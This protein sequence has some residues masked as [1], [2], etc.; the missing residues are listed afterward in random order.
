V[1]CDP[2]QACRRFTTAALRHGGFGVTSASTADQAL[3]ILRRRLVKAMVIDPTGSDGVEALRAIRLRTEIPVIVVSRLTDECDKVAMLD[4]GA[5]DYL[6]KPFGSEELLARLRVALRRSVQPADD[7]PVETPDF[8]IDFGARRFFRRDGSE[9]RLTPTEWLL[10]E[11]LARRPGRVVGHA[12]LL[13]KVWG[14]TH[15]NA[16][17]YLR[18]YMATIR[19]KLEPDPSHPRYFITSPGLGLTFLPDRLPNRPQM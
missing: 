12:Q 10:V 14:P 11:I 13:R 19:R 8:V 2:D 15:E 7:P 17:N 9:V 18:T 3:L 4:A 5:D 16:T 1:V 6:V